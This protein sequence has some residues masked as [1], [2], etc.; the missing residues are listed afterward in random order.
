MSFR[1]LFP[2][3]PEIITDRLRLREISMGDLNSFYSIKSD[4]D[5]TFPYAM[6]PH[7]DRDQT[8]KWIYNIFDSYEK[9]DAVMWAIT[10]KDSS[11]VLGSVT[12]WNI[13]ADSGCGELGYEL[14]KNAWGKGFAKE[15][16]RAAT[17]FGFSR[18]N[19]NRIEACPY[20][21]NVSSVKL[22]ENIGYKLE[23]T[24]RERVRFNG[25]Y[26]DQLYF[27]VLKSEWREKR[28]S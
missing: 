9:E 26:K 19:L 16:A 7:K 1:D 23:G 6:R 12:L 27:A 10:Q 20:S 21:D 22:L 11:E 3:F 28:T 8:K 18:L 13:S 25:A 4:P 24:L 2:V 5:V 17:E 15:A 14:H